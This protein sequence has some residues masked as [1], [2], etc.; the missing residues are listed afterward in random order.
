MQVALWAA[1]NPANQYR[2]KAWECLC[3]AEIVNDPVERVEM[4][5]FARIWMDLAE[6]PPDVPG[7]EAAASSSGKL[8]RD[9]TAP[10]SAAAWDH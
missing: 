2:A 9:R 1:M 10:A 3:L 4:L 8:H 5:R 7:L 6:P